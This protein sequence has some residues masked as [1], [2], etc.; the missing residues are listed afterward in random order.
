MDASEIR[1]LANHQLEAIVARASANP[2]NVR[3]VDEGIIAYAERWR[4]D[5]DWHQVVYAPVPTPPLT[6][7]LDGAHFTLT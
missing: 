3:L 5:R 1:R 4:R 7:E 6:D 2:D